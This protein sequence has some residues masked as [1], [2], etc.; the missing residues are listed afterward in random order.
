MKRLFISIL[1]VLVLAVP[2]Y[3]HTVINVPIDGR[4]VS[5]EYLAELARIGGDDCISVSKENL[6]FFPAYVP[7]TREGKS[8]NVRRELDKLVS[9][10]NNKATTVIINTSSYITNGLVGSRCGVNYGSYKEALEELHSLAQK[11]TEPRYYVNIQ[12][13]RSLPETRFNKIWCDDEK[14]KGLAYYYLKYNDDSPYEKEMSAYTS[15]TPEQYIME[16]SYVANKAEELGIKNITPWEREF[17]NYFSNNIRSKAPYK[18]YVDNYIKP[19]EASADMFRI[20]TDYM[21]EGCI[22]EIVISNDDLQV[23]NFITYCFSKGFDWVQSENG[24]PVKYSYARTYMESGN[25]SVHRA[26][27]DKFPL[28]RLGDINTCRDSSINIIYGTD[29]VPQLIY[30]RDYTRRCNITPRTELVYN[31]TS[32]STATFDVKAPGSLARAAL[33]F[34]N[35][36]VANYSKTPACVYIYDYRLNKNTADMVIDRLAAA[37]KKGGYTGLIELFDLNA[38]NTVFKEILRGGRFS[39]PQLD[40]YCAW[41]TNGNAI[42]LGIAQMQ[43]YAAAMESSK[44]TRQTMEAQLKC[45]ICHAVEDGLYTKSG[46]LALSN[47]GYRPNVEDRT[48]SKTLFELL[49]TDSITSALKGAEYSILGRKY[50]VKSAEVTRLSFPWGRTFDIYVDSSIKLERT[51]N[52]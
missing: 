35:G 30:A 52:E 21:A 43:V 31:D 20:L 39:L 3:A 33:S 5:G 11:Y 47:K 19:Y 34:V 4:P 28:K 46:K 8:E 6:D 1:F 10:H 42:G 12:M 17:L 37:D 7:D 22:D 15:V 36:S 50:T 29:E 9:E 18:Q 25:R 16:F 49:D 38:S 13:P 24:S 45:L 2:A 14:L 26:I 51:K 23:P 44:D 40:M 41:N 48:N 32:Q 27:K